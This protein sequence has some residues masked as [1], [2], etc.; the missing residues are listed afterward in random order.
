MN[1]NATN[2]EPYRAIHHHYLSWGKRWLDLCI[3]LPSLI[4]AMPIM[5]ILALAIY[6]ESPGRVLFWQWRV[7]Q[8]GRIFRIWKLRTMHPN[9]EAEGLP[10]LSGPND[11]RVTRFGYWLRLTRLDE[12]P[13]LWNILRGDMSLV[14]PRP[15]RPYFS[16]SYAAV[17]PGY[18]LRH[19]MRPGLT[20]WAQVQLGYCSDLE[21]TRVKTSFDLDYLKR[22]SPGLD[23]CIL[24]LWTPRMLLDLLRHS[25]VFCFDHPTSSR[26]RFSGHA[27]TAMPDMGSRI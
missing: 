10:L 14:G 2:D 18:S 7:G 5:L 16:A 27:V 22:I 9:A 15:E 6:C 25:P 19:R 13:Q 3:C 8:N 4:L 26:G 20:G 11:S 12:W 21:T 24:F 1:M 17:I 23:L